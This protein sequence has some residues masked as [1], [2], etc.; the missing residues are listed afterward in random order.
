MFIFGVTALEQIVDKLQQ[1]PQYLNSI[2]TIPTLKNNP[3]LY[4]KVIEKYNEINNKTKGKEIPL[5]D[6]KN[7]QFQFSNIVKNLKNLKK[8]NFRMKKKE[9][10]RI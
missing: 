7:N 3:Q 8:F 10:I 4:E 2:V 9:Q 6:M 5:L 1:W